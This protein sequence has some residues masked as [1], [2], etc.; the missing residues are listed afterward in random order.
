MVLPASGQ[1]SLSQVR[2]ELGGP[3]AGVRLSYYHSTTA[4]SPY[5]TDLGTPPTGS[6]IPVSSLRGKARPHVLP[7]VWLSARMLGGTDGSTVTTWA[8]AV[9]GGA[10]ATGA[11]KS[12]TRLPLQ[13][14]P[15]GKERYVACGTNNDEYFTLPSATY[16]M[17]S[18][19]AFALVAAVRMRAD[20]GYQRIFHASAVSGTDSIEITQAGN[21]DLRFR[22]QYYSSGDASPYHNALKGYFTVNYWCVLG[23]RIR[24]SP[25]NAND[26]WLNSTTKTAATDTTMNGRDFTT[27]LHQIGRSPTTNDPL[28][29]ID[30]REL[31]LFDADMSDEDMSAAMS[32]MMSR[33]PVGV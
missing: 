17:S 30:L 27:A 26:L 7:T 11:S 15:A 12:G 3:T 23:W 14:A 2:S 33:N 4:T 20:Q 25:N 10:A 13:Y 9:N 28:S 22:S 24:K 18:V 31:M 5:A 8:S 6:P 29:K 19:G 32:K 16:H 1:I 21:T